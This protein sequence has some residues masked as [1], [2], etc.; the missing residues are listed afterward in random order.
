MCIQGEAAC[1]SL[2]CARDM[3]MTHGLEVAYKAAPSRKFSLP[4]SSI[5]FRVRQLV[6]CTR[7]AYNPLPT[8]FF[9]LV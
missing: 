8:H 2:A 4:S 7:S 3:Y 9:F 5:I 1:W 6:S